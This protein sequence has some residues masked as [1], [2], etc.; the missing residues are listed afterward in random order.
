MLSITI[1]PQLHNFSENKVIWKEKLENILSMNNGK[2]TRYVL[3]LEGNESHF[4]I[5]LETTMRTDSLRRLLV[6]KLEFKPEDDNEAK[7]W[8]KVA[9]H[10]NP[11]YLIG[12]CMK[13][14]LYMSNFP[15]EYLEECF[16]HYENLKE[17]IKKNK[18]SDKWRC[19]G[20]NNLFPLVYSFMKEN[21]LQDLPIR[22]IIC[23]LHANDL[24]PL[25]LARKISHKEEDL[26]FSYK[27]MK[28]NVDLEEIVYQLD[29]F[30]NINV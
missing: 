12:Y 7:Q 26:W 3:G 11:K 29:K 16:K 21:G 10:N 13:E 1:R 18:P 5:A 19:S 9:K 14:K 30:N 15:Q 20:M 6:N 22:S 27:S 17:E 28:D 8:L 25:S 24:I 23:L 2:L 4:Q